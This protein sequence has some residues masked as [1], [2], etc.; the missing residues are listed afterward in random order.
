MT[1][2]SQDNDYNNIIVQNFKTFKTL[3]QGE[4]LDSKKRKIIKQFQQA[5][6]SELADFLF[7]ATLPRLNSRLFDRAVR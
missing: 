1:R 7:K 5:Q 2:P 3:K 6:P 4:N